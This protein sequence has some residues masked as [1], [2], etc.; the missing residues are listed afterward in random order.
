ML[1]PSPSYRYCQNN[2]LIYPAEREG[3]LL[4]MIQIYQFHIHPV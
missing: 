1:V 2:R 3:M 4:P